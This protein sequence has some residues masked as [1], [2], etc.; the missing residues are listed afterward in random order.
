MADQSYKQWPFFTEEHRDLAAEIDAWAASELAWLSAD[1]HA[2]VDASCKKLVKQ[3]GAAGWLKNSVPAAAGGNYP[4]L[5]VRSLCL[6]RQHLAYHSGLA[7]FAFA[8]QGLGSGPISL[9]A[10]PEIQQ[11]YLPGVAKGELIAAFALSEPDAGSDVAAMSTAAVADGDDYVL[12]GCKTWISNGGIADFYTVFARTNEAPGAKGISCFVVDADT[13]GFSIKERIEVIAP[14]P[15]ATLSFNDCRIPKSQMIGQPGKGFGIAMATLDVFRSTVG[16]A[17]LGFARRALDE[18]GKHTTQRQIFGGKLSDLAITQSSLG[19]MA[20]DIDTSAL[21][22]YRSAWTKDTLG[23][24][25]TREAAMAKFYA[26]EAAQR[27]IDQALQLHGG[28]GVVSGN[29]VE[30]LYRE[31]RAL[32]IYEGASEVQKVIMGQQALR[33]FDV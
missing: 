18:A 30:S 3:L 1:G 29:M 21:L 2:D 22:I 7:D 11:R 25:V 14:H 13:P 12:N 20:L 16:A 23:S 15:L 27:V 19:E 9:F 32:R 6:S 10:D 5:D 17:A 31:I 4:Q 26:T 24:R 28:L 33:E 8:M